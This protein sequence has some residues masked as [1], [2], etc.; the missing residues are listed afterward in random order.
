MWTQRGKNDRRSGGFREMWVIYKHLFV[1]VRASFRKERVAKYRNKSS[2]LGKLHV[3]FPFSHFGP[4]TWSIKWWWCDVFRGTLHHLWARSRYRCSKGQ[5]CCSPNQTLRG[6][7]EL[8]TFPEIVQN[9]CTPQSFWACARSEECAS[10]LKPSRESLMIEYLTS[11]SRAGVRPI[12]S[13][14]VSW[15]AHFFCNRGR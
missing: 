14:R 2:M 15:P 10:D 11:T 4:L 6:N 13:P 1:E 12:F 9:V 3:I 5:V 8:H 7:T